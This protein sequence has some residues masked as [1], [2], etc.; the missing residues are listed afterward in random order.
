M[1]WV[2][3]P[4]GQSWEGDY[5]WE[6]ILTELIIPLFHD[7][8]NVL[9]VTQVTFL[10]DKAP[11]MIVLETQN[12]LKD[13]NIDFFR[14]EEWPGNF[15]DLNACENVGSILK[16]EVEKRMLSEPLATRYSRIK[17]EEHIDAVLWGMEFNT[18]LCVTF[19]FLPCSS[20][21]CS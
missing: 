15:P 11:C 4:R 19:V 13:S 6:K 18:E 8:Q 3:K 5:F 14:N 10:H 21:S 9:D 12:L 20:L 7:H 16:D 2:V 1:I 17:M